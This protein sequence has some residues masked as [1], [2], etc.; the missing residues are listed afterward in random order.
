MT[1]PNEECYKFDHVRT[2]LQSDA[3]RREY[4]RVNALIVVANSIQKL[5]SDRGM[6]RSELA[7]GMGKSKAFVSQILNGSRNL[8][9][10]TLAE[11]LAALDLELHG[12]ETGTLGVS[13]VSKD[14]MDRWLDGRSVARA[15]L[16]DGNSLANAEQADE[17]CMVLEEAA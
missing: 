15:R 16:S 7:E 11:C 8:T 17:E 10:N 4:A 12:L 3:A 13:T 1:A 6:K 2:R 5:L 9:I 14:A